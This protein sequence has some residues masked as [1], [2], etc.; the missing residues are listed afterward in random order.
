MKFA[1]QKFEFD[2]GLPVLVSL[3]LVAVGV[4][5]YYLLSG[6]G[7]LFVAVGVAGLIW[8]WIRRP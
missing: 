8:C 1:F 3:A 6:F 5:V 2:L 4:P 7:A